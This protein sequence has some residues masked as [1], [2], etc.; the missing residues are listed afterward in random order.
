MRYVSMRNNLHLKWVKKFHTPGPKHWV[1]AYPQNLVA[2][3]RAR[4]QVDWR[5]GIVVAMIR[6]CAIEYWPEAFIRMLMRLNNDIHSVLE[7]QRFK[8]EKTIV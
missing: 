8:A 4:Y 2:A 7:K 5:L 6:H 1:Q 3:G